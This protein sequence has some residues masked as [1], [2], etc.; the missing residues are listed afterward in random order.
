MKTEHFNIICQKAGNG[1][2]VLIAV[3]PEDIFGIDLPSISE[4]HAIR[5]VPT[6]FTGTYPT[7]RIID[8]TFKSRDDL[9]GQGVA[10]IVTGENWYNTSQEDKN[11]LGIN[12]K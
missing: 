11:E 3:V 10:G 5:T 2:M 4:V 8:D 12:L 1:K 6:V 7:I 9:K